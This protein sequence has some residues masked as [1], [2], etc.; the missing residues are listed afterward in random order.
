MHHGRIILPEVPRL[1]AIEQS[2]ERQ[3]MIATGDS[4]QSCQHGQPRHHVERTNTVN[5]EHSCVRVGFRQ[6][7]QNVGHAFRTCS[8][9]QSVLEWS[10]ETFHSRHNLLED[11]P[12]DQTPHD[13]TRNDAPDSPIRFLERCHPPHADCFDCHLRRFSPGQLFPCSEEPVQISGSGQQVSEM[14]R[15]Q[16]GPGAAPL[17]DDL[18]FCENLF[19]SRANGTSGMNSNI[20]GGNSLTGLGERLSMFV[21]RFRV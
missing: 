1:A 13:I 9:P 8:S 6:R 16:G 10:C 4:P 7:L 11:S 19:S 17:R 2:N 5:G 14:F 18:R 20:S 3:D 21:N 15:S 12:T